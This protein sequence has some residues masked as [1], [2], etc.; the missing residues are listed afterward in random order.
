[1]TSSNRVPIPLVPDPAVAKMEYVHLHRTVVVN[2]VTERR[3]ESV[4]CLNDE[5]G[6]EAALK[7]WTEFRDAWDPTRLH[8][9][10]ACG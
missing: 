6:A 10:S 3:K 8:L 2:G 1:M 4:P 7:H 5:S 9:P